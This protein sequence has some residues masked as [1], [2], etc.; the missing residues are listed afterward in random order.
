MKRRMH[1]GVV[2]VYSLVLYFSSC[3]AFYLPG[4]APV[5]FCEEGNGSEDCQT[6][7]TLF[8]NRL[9]SVESVLPYE[10]DVFDFCKDV[11]EMRP[12]ENLGQVLFGER[13]ESSPY[14][15]TFKKNVKCNS[16]CTKTY[17]KGSQEDATK[18]DFLKMGMQLNYQH[19]WIID[20]MPVTW[21]YDVEDGQK[22]CNPGF[23][24]GC[25]VTTDGRAKD[26]CVINAEFN[27]K[28]TFYVFNHV[29]IKITFHSGTGEDWKGARLV[30]A[31]L[32]PKSI[33]Q[34]DEKNLNCETGVPMEVPGTFEADVS[35]V[36][37]YSVTFQE[38]N[39]IK[40]AS[41]WDYILVSMPHTNIQWFSIM[42]SLVI[43]LFLSGMVAMIM[44]RT[45]HK[46]IAR[47]NQVDQEDAQEE[48][49]WKQ[50]HGDVFRP[51]RKGML[52]SVFLGQGTQIFIMT[53]ITLFLA[54][55]GFLSP[56]NR[57]ALMTCSVV[58]WVLLG[59]PAGYV[60]ARLYKTFGGEKW[61]TNVLLTALLCPG[62][63]FADFFLMNL[64]LWVEGSSAA[65]PFG[66]LVAILALWFGISV[67]LTFIGAYFGFKKP[68][69]EQPVRT[70]QIPRQ[71]PEQSFFTK[72]IPGIVMGG[73]LPFGCIF[74]Q[75]FFILN[76][77]WSHQMYYMFGFLF[78][79]FIILLITCSEAT[80]L[81]CYFHLC[82]EDYHWW[83]RSFLTSGFTAVYLFVYAIHYFFSKLQIVGA[84]S[85]ILYFGYTM[86]MVLI[87]FLFTGTIG[88]FACFWFVNKIYSVVK[89]D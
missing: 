73:I 43:V 4:L 80:I 44:L 71:I 78:L 66:T 84:A 74:I 3:S 53:F 79:V 68:A 25:L 22:Y 89:V 28:N 30:A 37:T 69:I 18:L 42:N 59:T 57:G 6:G 55:L 49:G 51:P 82:A 62:I 17:K 54:C 67:P 5:S 33:K 61:K 56:A 36:Y 81:L 2:L 77:I 47:Y 86:I 65:I 1:F 14:Q 23:P 32:E 26:A 58:L 7:I 75:L 40:W 10:Y 19:H 35:V 87:F 63:V 12:S 52:L 60:S 38:N 50:V 39:S 15:V 72:P 13:I 45:L 29:D 64:I 24:I 9:D 76:S 83:W 16:V 20:N 11:K 34:T 88:F 85:T 46:D 8:V 31:T 48:S 27:K 41:R 21:C 70:N